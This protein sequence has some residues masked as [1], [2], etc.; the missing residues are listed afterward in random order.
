[1]VQF[2]YKGVDGAGEPISGTVEAADRGCAVAELA[3]MGRFATDLAELA[4]PGAAVRSG[5]NMQSVLKFNRL[6]SGRVSSKDILAVTS[7]LSTALRAGLAVLDALE[8]IGAQQHKA[9]MKELLSDLADAVR[10]GESLSDAMSKKPEVFS[11][12]YVSMVSVGE[13]GGIL[14][15]T[16]TQLTKLLSRDEKI[17]TN[18][19]NASAYPIFVA[20]LGIGSV[21]LFL[22]WI[23]P[24]I[25]NTIVGGVAALPLPTRMLVSSS[26]FVIRFGWLAGIVLIGGFYLFGKWKRS[27]EG[28]LKWDSFKLRVPVLGSV[29]RT[30]AVGRFART[31]GALTKSGITILNA[32]AV[33]RDTLGN[34]LLG[35]EIDEVASRV[36]TGEALAEPLADSGLFPPLL[37]QIVSVG[38]QTGQLD[39]LLLNAAETFDESA[40]AAI[41]RFM[42]LFPAVLILLLALV[43]GFIIIASL[44]PI[45]AMELGGAGI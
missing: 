21:I 13:T 4:G 1:M 35:R 45:V 20:T 16:M 41:T 23:L 36:K 5:A 10:G 22:V 9:P 29:L 34:E 3:K 25:I 11:R 42:T 19:K 43:I 37:V 39:E 33:V 31:L 27:P 14:D 12:L 28:L 40:D 15:S 32:L 2:N 38:E 26:N 8:I 18:M 17:K 7:Q 44:L 30:I 6:G 24:N